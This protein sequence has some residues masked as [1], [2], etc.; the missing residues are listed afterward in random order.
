M[1][2]SISC[3]TAHLPLGDA[4]SLINATLG[5][6]MA[7]QEGDFDADSRWALTWFEQNGFAEGAY[8]VADILSKAKKPPLSA[9]EAGILKSRHGKVRLLKPDELPADWDPENGTKGGRSGSTRAH[10]VTKPPDSLFRSGRVRGARGEAVRRAP[11]RWRPRR[12]WRFGTL[13]V[14]CDTVQLRA[15]NGFPGPFP[16]V[17]LTSRTKYCRGRKPRKADGYPA[18]AVAAVAPGAERSV[19]SDPHRP[20]T[21]WTA[22]LPTIS[23]PQE[24]ACLRSDRMLFARSPIS[25]VSC[26]TP[27][28][29]G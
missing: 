13:G 26:C 1:S 27:P 4:L 21:W 24:P 25:C 29:T 2:Y 23:P 16:R 8:G 6:A 28:P 11:R 20:V 3:A 14:W 10:Q 5:E 9:G 22:A 17:T 19:I 18:E 15:S 7:E 12:W